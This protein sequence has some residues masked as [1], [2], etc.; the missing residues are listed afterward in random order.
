MGFNFRKT[1]NLGNGL[2]LNLGKKS[3]SVSV[4]KKGIHHSISTTG[5]QTTTVG[6]PGTGVSYS[7]VT[8]TKKSAAEKKKAAEKKEKAVI[9]KEKEKLNREKAKL[10]QEK[11]ELERQKLENER[12]RLEKERA[13]LEGSTQQTSEP[14]QEKKKFSFKKQKPS[15]AENAVGE[16]P[17]AVPETAS[18]PYSSGKAKKSY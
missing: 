7:H 14:V 12:L 17:A 10:E 1:I 3:A 15:S 18:N 2:K 9:S 11:L 16:K 4:G 13:E 8:G 5:R 6:I